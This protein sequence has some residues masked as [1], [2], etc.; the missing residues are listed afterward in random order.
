M[1]KGAVLL[2]LDCGGGTVDITVHKLQCHV[3]E[4]FLS[5]ELL[6]SSGGQEWGSKYVDFYYEE[7]LNEFLQES[8]FEKYKKNGLARLDILKDF[9]IVKRKFKG[10]V[11]ERSMAKFSYMGEE[12]T[13]PILQQL[14]KDYN[15]NAPQEYH[16]KLKGAANVE[17]PGTLV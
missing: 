15:A 13:T 7:F 3:K 4:R 9:E 8:Y 12:L 11:T 16:L 1:P 17:L 10:G 5:Q 14:I 6:P 2:V